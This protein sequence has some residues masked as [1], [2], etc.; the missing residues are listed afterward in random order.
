MVE[1]AL[2]HTIRHR[3]MVTVEGTS[4]VALAGAAALLAGGLARAAVRVECGTCQP[5]PAAGGTGA[6]SSSFS[7]QD[8][9]TDTQGF[10]DGDYL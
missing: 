10:A 2:H 6:P 3:E 5:E 1:K 7:E 8:H 9:H 4:R